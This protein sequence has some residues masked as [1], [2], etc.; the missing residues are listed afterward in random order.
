MGVTGS[1]GC[2]SL[3]G[4]GGDGSGGDGTPTDSVAPNFEESSV[5]GPG[6]VTYGDTATLTVTVSNGG[7]REGSFTG[8]LRATSSDLEYEQR[9]DQT[10]A[11]G[12]SVTVESRSISFG[13]VGEYTFELVS[14]PDDSSDD[15]AEPTTIDSSTVPV[16]SAVGSAGDTV[17]VSENLR[18]TVQDV[19]FRDVVFTGRT[20]VSGAFTAPT[21]RVLAV[22]QI[23]VENVGTVEERWRP[24]KMSAEGG[25]LYGGSGPRIP[26]SQ[27]LGIRRTLTPSEA[28]PGYLVAQ[29]P[30]DVA[31]TEAPLTL[32]TGRPDSD[33]EYRWE[34]TAS[35]ERTFPAFRLESVD[36]P[37]TVPKGE[38]YDITFRLHN[39]GDAGGTLKA[40][41]QSAEFRNDDWT[42]LASEQFIEQEIGV[43]ETVAV[44]V[45]TSQSEVGG[46]FYYRLAP[47]IGREWT[48]EFTN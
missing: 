26:E 10:V 29:F 25:E 12:E 37:S 48:T 47:F 3:L 8:Q 21:G 33:P 45:S 41:P 39:E 34:F 44:S 17:A 23:R 1:A 2:S 19:E 5:E 18:L 16:T 31:K 36:A 30:R 15:D 24:S 28:V 7:E 32:R 42:P 46:T 4:A 27:Y 35:S 40:V 38:E 13:S 6:E 20:D 11:G 43:D 9:I 14:E 22:Y